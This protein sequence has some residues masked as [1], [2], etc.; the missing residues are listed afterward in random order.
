MGNEQSGSS[1]NNASEWKVPEINAGILIKSQ[2]MDNLNP[3][4]AGSPQ[5]PTSARRKKGRKIA[6]TPNPE[7]EMML[8]SY[9]DAPNSDK[10]GI[11]TLQN[12]LKL[13]CCEP[14]FVFQPF[15][16][17]EHDPNDSDTL[18]ALSLKYKVPVKPLVLINK[19]YHSVDTL[20]C[21]GEEDLI[22]ETGGSESKRSVIFP[23]HAKI[24]AMVKNGPHFVPKKIQNAIY[25]D[26]FVSVNENGITIKNFYAP[27][28]KDLV[29][30]L[31][32]HF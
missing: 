19:R 7:A 23:L 22:L 10:V 32:F 9:A 25:D 28:G 15:F 12:I 20:S 29:C 4:F 11:E 2:S 21:L 30:F 6:Q 8:M 26:E 24:V 27:N 31:F 16:F 17:L 14:Q 5:T 1:N 3:K 13:A 18:V